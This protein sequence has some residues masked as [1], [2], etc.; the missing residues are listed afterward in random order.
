MRAPHCITNQFAGEDVFN[1]SK[2]E[3]ALVGRYVRNIGDPDLVG[4]RRRNEV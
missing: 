2:V 1:T 4:P 3:P